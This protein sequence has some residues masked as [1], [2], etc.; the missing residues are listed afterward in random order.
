MKLQFFYI[1]FWSVNAEFKWSAK[2]VPCVKK[3]GALRC[4]YNAN[5]YQFDWYNFSSPFDQ[6]I[7]ATC[8]TFR[9]NSN[10]FTTDLTILQYFYIIWLMNADFKPSIKWVPF[11][12]KVSNL[13]CK[14]VSIYFSFIAITLVA[15]SISEQTTYTTFRPNRKKL[16]I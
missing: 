8:T 14:K 1:I 10:N 15:P 2:W 12:K 11:V 13:R 6:C 4:K 3:K 5:L 16:T 9:P 7:D